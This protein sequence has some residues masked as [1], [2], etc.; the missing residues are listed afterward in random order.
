VQDLPESIFKLG[1]RS[2]SDFEHADLEKFF[3]KHL[4]AGMKRPKCK[5]GSY[6][7]E[8]QTGGGSTNKQ[9]LFTGIA[10]FADAEAAQ[11]AIE[12]M[13]AKGP[14]RIMTKNDPD[15]VALNQVPR[16]PH[17]TTPYP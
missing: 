4:P 5:V 3:D 13:N 10:E 1:D 7:V 17:F 15:V 12:A 11:K 16:P 8:E 14:L 6:E 9:K 2:L